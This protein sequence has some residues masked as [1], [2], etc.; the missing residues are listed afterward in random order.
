M[1]LQR[2]ISVVGRTFA[3]GLKS[4]TQL[5]DY[6]TQNSTSKRM[7]THSFSSLL[8]S[9]IWNVVLC[10]TG[11]AL[12]EALLMFLWCFYYIVLEHLCIIFR[13]KNSLNFPRVV[14]HHCYI[15]GFQL[16]AALCWSTA[17]TK[18]TDNTADK[19]M[20]LAHSTFAFTTCMLLKISSWQCSWPCLVLYQQPW[21]CI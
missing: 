17:N 14:A 10:I 3:S 9:C 8:I 1:T 2:T 6:T 15:A 13:T 19:E 16:E 20:L 11:I 7:W 18:P 12:T 21:W 4:I 5:R